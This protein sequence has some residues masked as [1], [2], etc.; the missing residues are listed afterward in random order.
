[1]T[2]TLRSF[3]TLAAGVL[4]LTASACSSPEKAPEDNIETAAA[5][6]PAVPE[7]TEPAAAPVQQAPVIAQNDSGS[8]G[9]W[10]A[11]STGRSR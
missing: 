11:S 1:M 3:V 2:I 4:M 6:A 7:V 5:T 10:G 8:K 9:L